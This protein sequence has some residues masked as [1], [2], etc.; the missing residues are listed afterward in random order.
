M[1]RCLST[2]VCGV[3]HT[4]CINDEGNVF[5]F[6]HSNN[7]AHGFVEDVIS[8]KMIPT[9]GNIKTIATRADHS[10]CLDDD[11]NVFTFGYNSCGQ[12]GTVFDYS[13]KESAHIPQ[14]VDLPLCIQISCGHSF[15]V[16]LTDDHVLYSFGSNVFGELGLGTNEIIYNSPQLV[17][18]LKD[19]EFIECG[20]SHVFCKT[21]NNEVYCWGYNH[22]GQLGLGNKDNQNI[23]MLCSSIIK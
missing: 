8:P 14:K 9:L 20:T 21:L 7:G 5:S 22:S 19:V 13:T 12:L 4:I 16:C 6:G 11:G 2:I 17:S 10:V 18:S 23:P 15:T 3:N 1:K